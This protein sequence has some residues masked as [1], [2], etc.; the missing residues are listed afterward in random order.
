MGRAGAGK[1]K[2]RDVCVMLWNGESSLL[3]RLNE[4]VFEV[5]SLKSC[6]A[7]KKGNERL[8]MEIWEEEAE[9]YRIRMDFMSITSVRNN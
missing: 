2:F 1:T 6:G 4:N 8:R 7:R 3:P 5:V 9:K